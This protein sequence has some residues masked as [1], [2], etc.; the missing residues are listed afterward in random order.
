M[1]IKAQDRLAGEPHSS[2]GTAQEAV[3]WQRDIPEATG[4][5]EWFNSNKDTSLPGQKGLG[6]LQHNWDR[7]W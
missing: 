7:E 5:G 1:F 2:P 4:R 3:E 6:E